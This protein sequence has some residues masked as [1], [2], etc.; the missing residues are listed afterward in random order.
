MP[1]SM[2]YRVVFDLASTGVAWWPV[3]VISA[4][5]AAVIFGLS[6]QIIAVASSRSKD[7]PSRF[8]ERYIVIAMMVAA[9]VFITAVVYTVYA[10]EL[11]LIAEERTSATIVEGVVS[12]F[13]PMPYTGHAMERFCVSATCFAYSDYVITGGF[14]NASSHGGPIREGLHVRIKHV[15]GVIVRL[16]VEG[17]RP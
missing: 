11:R 17:E 7:G 4:I 14:N 5:V 6:K 1:D 15:N 12:H 8:S 9:F 2:S 3:A 13:V 16:E 10:K